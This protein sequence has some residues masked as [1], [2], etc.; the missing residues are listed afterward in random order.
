[1]TNG[2]KMPQTIETL[3]RINEQHS[4]EFLDQKIERIR[5]RGEHPTEICA[6]KC[7]DG[8]LNLP[9]MTE[10]ALGVI[11][12][13]RNLGGKFSLGWPLFQNLINE[14]VNYA[15]VRGRH[16]LVL[17]TYHKSRG[18]DHRG[19]AGFNYETDKAI[20]A[21]KTLKAQFDRVYGSGVSTLVCGIET[22][23]DALI[24]HG[25]GGEVLDLAECKDTSKAALTAMLQEFY[26]SFPERVVND[27]LP[28]VEGNVRHIRK[29]RAS[30]RPISDIVHKEWVLGIGR[31]FDWLHL[32]NTAFIVGPYDLKLEVAI[33]TAGGLLLK[34]LRE[35]RL[36]DDKLVM[37]TSAG[38]RSAGPEQRLA[39]EKAKDLAEYSVEILHRKVPDI[40]DHLQVLTST[41]NL[42]TRKLD[43][44]NRIEKASELFGELVAV[45]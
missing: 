18:D 21:A 20:T 16:S 6:L 26:P 22:D 29:I 45:G 1:M 8:R 11:Q 14:W 10:T 15:I 23:L 25:E 38:Y 35:G 42:D 27:L 39:E 41:V 44:I 17:V 13:F 37:M 5:Y 34:N 9:V 24:L 33:E 4:Q 3:L 43:V 32:V 12:P 30:N 2:G 19:C 36:S 28:L 40:L 31:A 7:M